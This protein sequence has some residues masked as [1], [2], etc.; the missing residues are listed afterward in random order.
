MSDPM[1]EV[2]ALTAVAALTAIREACQEADLNPD[3]VD[4]LARLYAAERIA[5]A[6]EQISDA[7]RKP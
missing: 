5:I 3:W 1:Q 6:L 7:V 4:T 2:C